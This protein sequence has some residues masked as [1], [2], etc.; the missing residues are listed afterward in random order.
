MEQLS[1]FAAF[2]PA[3]ENMVFA[4]NWGFL[5]RYD[6]QH[7][8]LTVCRTVR[9]PG[10][11]EINPKKKTQKGAAGNSGKLNRNVKR[12]KSTVY[13]L[14][15]CNDWEWFVTLTFDKEK[16][17]SRYAFTELMASFRKWLSNYKSR[18]GLPNFRYLVVPEQHSD[19]AWHLHGLLSGIPERDLH[20]FS[21]DETIPYKIRERLSQGVPVYN[22][23]TYSRKF[24][25][26]TL[27]RVQSHEAVCKY[28]TKYI[29]KDLYRAVSQLN[30]HMYYASA[31]LNRAELLHSGSILRDFTPDFENDYVKIKNAASPV[32]LLPLF[33]DCEE[34]GANFDF[35]PMDSPMAGGLQ[36]GHHEGTFLPSA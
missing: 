24:G 33:C 16:V 15:L 6:N 8:K 2:A 28:I 18:R 5:R 32:D 11:E 7:S 10:F 19:G 4:H 34:G 14:A 35:G 22:W 36:A 12:A 21:L 3:S 13:E 31:K 1:H 29:T 30:A 26:T 25:Y 23:T 9:R 17:S 27:E 20:A